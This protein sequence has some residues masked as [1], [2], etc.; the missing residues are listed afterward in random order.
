VIKIPSIAI[1]DGLTLNGQ[2]RIILHTIKDR[3]IKFDSGWIDNVLPIV[4]RSALAGVLTG[5]NINS[6]PGEVTFC[7]VGDGVVI[8]NIN[9]I[10][11]DNEVDRVTISDFSQPVGTEAQIRAFFTSTEGNGDLTE[12]GLF[13]EDATAAADSGT[14]F[15]W[16]A[17]IITKT[18][19]ETM[20][21]LSKIPF[22]YLGT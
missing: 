17:F 10:Q 19:L 4:G 7:A 9:G 5:K 15:Q 12:I 14:F 11:L 22:N 6:N 13:G 21:I 2:M 20:T 3:S 16:V 18:S 1:T 8:P